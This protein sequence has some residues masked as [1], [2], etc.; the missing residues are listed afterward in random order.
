MPR[1][2]SAARAMRTSFSMFLIAPPGDATM[3]QLTEYTWLCVNTLH[4]FKANGDYNCR[5]EKRKMGPKAGSVSVWI[6]FERARL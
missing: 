1:R 4:W 6:C 2:K 5:V 3:A